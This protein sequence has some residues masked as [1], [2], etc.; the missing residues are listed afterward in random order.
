[1][2]YSSG[3][4]AAIPFF[5]QAV[6]IDPNFAI[7]YAN[8]GLSYSEAGLAAEITPK[9]YQLRD[10]ASEQERYF[11]EAMYYRQIS[12]DLEKEREVL[13]RRAQNYPRAVELHGLLAGF[14]ALGTGRYEMAIEQAKKALALNPNFIFGYT[15]QASGYLYLDRFDESGNA[16][17]QAATHKLEAPDFVI[18]RYYLAFLGGDDAEVEREIA[19]ARSEGPEDFLSQ[20]QALVMARSG[21]LKQA[22]T[23]SRRA[24]DLAEQSGERERAAAFQAGRARVGIVLWKFG[25]GQAERICGVGCVQGPRRGICRCVRA[26]PIRRSLA[27]SDLDGRSGKAV[28]R[29]FRR[30]IR[31]CSR[32]AGTI[33]AG[34]R[35]AGRGD[36]RAGDCAS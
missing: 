20:S 32:P 17:R 25:G 23:L 15:N 1:L 5:R 29:G 30:S 10:H 18:F 22:G 11:I 13:G 4:A 7:A 21:R 16:L 8:L 19:R 3:G 28:S 6:E 12:G 26:G 9:A 2:D 33:G 24:V 36:W 14:A 27:L 35:A 31:L 34:S